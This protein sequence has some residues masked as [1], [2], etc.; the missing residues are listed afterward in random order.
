MRAFA[1]IAL[2][3]H[4]THVALGERPGELDAAV[5]LAEGVLANDASDRQASQSPPRRSF[6][7]VPSRGHLPVHHACWRPFARASTVDRPRST[8]TRWA[9]R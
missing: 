7:G 2:A 9:G 6:A 8:T 3:P 5:H 1:V 4:S